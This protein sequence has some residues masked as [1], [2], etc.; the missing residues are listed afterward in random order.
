MEAVKD[1]LRRANECDLL[2]ITATTTEH[3]QPFLSR[4]ATTKA[5]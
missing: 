4:N 1:Y 5:C 2:A 3:R